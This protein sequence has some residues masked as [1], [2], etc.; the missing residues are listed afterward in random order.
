MKKYLIVKTGGTFDEFTREHG[1]FEHWTIYGMGLNLDECLCVDVSKGDKLPAPE[2]FAGCVITGSHDMVTD[3]LPWIEET[4]CWIRTAVAVGLPLLGICFGHQLMARALGGDAGYHP[5]GLEIGTVSISLTEA[6]KV[7][8]LFSILSPVFQA[9]VTHSQT[10]LTLPENAV[11]L[12]AND[13]DPYQGFRVGE[14]AWGVQFHPEFDAR[15]MCYYVEELRGLITQQG[16]DADAV[17]SG[18]RETPE[19]ASLLV[20]FVEL[21]REFAT[22]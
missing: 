5:D 17:R 1:D 10:V 21:C 7:D 2:A 8:P 13:H 12:A 16:G 4:A 19:V 15:A 20:R 14:S 3:V 11:S 18:I 6:G 9:H 22:R